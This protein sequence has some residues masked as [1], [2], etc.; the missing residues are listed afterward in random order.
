MICLG[1]ISEQLTVLLEKEEHIVLYWIESES[2]LLYTI[3][4]YFIL[5]LDSRVYRIY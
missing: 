1:M 2:R 5:G 4:G 3:D